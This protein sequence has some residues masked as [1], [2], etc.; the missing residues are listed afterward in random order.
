VNDNRVSLFVWAVGLIACGVLMLLLNFNALATY[1]PLAQY[2]LAGVLA[3]VSAS[4]FVAYMTQRAAWWRLIPAWTM[5]ALAMMVLGSTWDIDRR[6]TASFLFAGQA[7]AF[8]HVYALNRGEHWWALIPGGF[9]AALGTTV[10]ISVT[11]QRVETLGAIL[12]IGMGLV[13]FVLYAL[14]GRRRHWWA[15]IPGSALAL[16]GLFVFTY[17][18]RI[19]G[20]L[21]RWW[22]LI[23]MIVGLILGWQAAQRPPP[24]KMTINS[25]PGLR[26]PPPSALLAAEQP[27]ELPSEVAPPAPGASIDSVPERE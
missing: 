13:F 24:A 25:A 23:L 10:A 2:L 12:L 4:F 8:L 1:E 18:S 11:I 6:L 17:D 21:V 16:F 27:P 14:A 9:M 22:P 20:T 5:A 15:L 3:V 7:F 19:G 26:R